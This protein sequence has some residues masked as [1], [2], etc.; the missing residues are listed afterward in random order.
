MSAA[1]V[2]SSAESR[3]RLLVRRLTVVAGVGAAALAIVAAPAFGA[4]P[5]GN[6]FRDVGTDV[7]P[8]FCGTG[9]QVNIAFDVRVNEWLAPHQGN[10]KSTS[11]GTITFTNPL[12]G[13]VVIQRFAGQFLDVTVSGDPAGIN[14]HDFTNKGLPELFKTPRGGVLTRDAGYIVFR[15]VFDGEAPLSTE[16]VVNK[17]PHPQADSNFELFCQIMPGALGL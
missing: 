14:V 9:K 8:D 4:N 15:V 2:V 7:D 17:G 11:S 13:N 6:H 16:I 3:L 1:D 5:Q 12:N 10:H